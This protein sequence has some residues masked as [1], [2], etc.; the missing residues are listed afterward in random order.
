MGALLRKD[1][2]GRTRI[3]Y[4]VWGML[5]VATTVL[6]LIG[7]TKIR[8][9]PSPA[10]S[11]RIRG[12][13]DSSRADRGL[14]RWE[15]VDLPSF[16][17]ERLDTNEQSSRSEGRRPPQGVLE[18]QSL[19]LMAMTS[20]EERRP[21]YYEEDASSLGALL[22]HD[23]LAGFGRGVR[24]AVAD[25][26]REYLRTRSGIFSAFA[27]PGLR[28][29]GPEGV[30]YVIG[31]DTKLYS[32][33]TQ[34]RRTPI[35]EAI[36]GNFRD[37]AFRYYRID[38]ESSQLLLHTPGGPGPFRGPDGRQYRVTENGNLERLD[39]EGRGVRVERIGGDGEFLGSDGETYVLTDGILF[40]KARERPSFSRD[41]I[42]G[43]GMFRGPTGQVYWR[44]EDGGLYSYDSKNELVE[45]NLSGSG[46][47]RGPDGTLYRLDELGNAEVVV[48]S[49]Q[50]AERPESSPSREQQ[51][52]GERRRMLTGP[53]DVEANLLNF[54]RRE[55]MTVEDMVSQLH[56]GTVYRRERPEESEA[57]PAERKPQRFL[58]LGQRIPFYLLSTVTTQFDSPGVVEAVVAEDVYFHDNYLPAGTRIY[59]RLRETGKHNRMAI[60]FRTLV[61]TKGRS[62]SIAAHAYD[63]NLNYG[64]EAYHKPTEEWVYGLRYGNVA[65]MSVIQQSL[66]VDRDGRPYGD[67]SAIYDL[68][69]ETMEDIEGTNKSYHILPAGTAGILMLTSRLALDW[70]DSNEKP[71]DMAEALMTAAE[72]ERMKE[73]ME[74]MNPVGGFP[75]E[76]LQTIMQSSH[77]AMSGA[78]R[79]M[80]ELRA[81]QSSDALRDIDNLFGN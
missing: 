12:V 73:A 72:L 80:E 10:E 76:L 68:L 1:A 63:V 27:E 37:M 42:S 34:G 64:L 75:Q 16:S 25:D 51:S 43:S 56:G 55:G 50:R 54:H 77:E 57:D 28:L 69:K 24:V 48:A 44:G 2:N 38:R 59:G 22:T 71:T 62:L 61:D 29:V 36:D 41:S 23:H 7:A 33:D 17:A 31:E 39:G 65:L 32:E 14:E 11:N 52:R 15:S 21:M 20:Q 53:A 70:E 79:R 46:Q 3:G 45:T 5:F 19:N 13:S 35:T 9:G 74:A 4:G 6:V 67:P 81:G 58:P 30:G 40:A 66:P 78:S 18:T 47:F 60:D 8:Q 26:G 49:G